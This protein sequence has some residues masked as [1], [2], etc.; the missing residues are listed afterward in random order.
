MKEKPTDH[1]QKNTNGNSK[2]KQSPKP[3]AS[4]FDILDSDLSKNYSWLM[5]LILG[6]VLLFSL[7]LFDQK[8]SLAGDDS[9]YI[10]RASEFIHS[11]K[12]PAFQGP[13]YPMVLGLVVAVFGI[14]LIPLKLFSLA[15]MLAFVYILFRIMRDRVPATILM[16]TLVVVSINSYFLY[17]ASQTYNEAFYLFI[18][19]LLLLVFFTKF[20]DQEKAGSLPANIK[21]HLLLAGC[22][23]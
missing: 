3:S 6:L 4:L 9:F 12:Y 5:W 8:I 7:L 14:S 13:L 18:Q 16:A 19:S 20:I 21:R 10:I 22:R 2:G 1:K 23:C 15:A 17:Y 11:F